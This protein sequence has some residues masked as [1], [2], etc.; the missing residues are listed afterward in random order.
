MCWIIGFL[1][2][3]EL[4]FLSLLD[5]WNPVFCFCCWMAGGFL[6]WEKR[7]NGKTKTGGSVGKWKGRGDG[8]GKREEWQ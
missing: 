3:G 5:Y 2:F 4:G 7:G 1:N 6:L 8:K